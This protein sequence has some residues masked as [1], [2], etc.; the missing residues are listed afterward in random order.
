[1][2]R[3]TFPL[4]DDYPRLRR[5]LLQWAEQHAYACALDNC[6]TDVDTYGEYELLLG[7]ADSDAEVCVN[8]EDL[9]RA[10]ASGGQPWFGGLNYALRRQFE[11]VTHDR[12]TPFIQ[13]EPVCLFAAQTVVAIDR[14]CTQVTITSEAPEATWQ[15]IQQQVIGEPKPI[16]RVELQSSF[17]REEYIDTVKAIRRR[18]KMGQ[19]YEINLSQ[20][21]TAE[22]ELP[23]RV[24]L[25]EALTRIS[26]VPFATYLKWGERY[27]IGASPERFMHK[28]GRKLLSQPIKGTAA[29]EPHAPEQDQQNRDALLASEKERAENVMIVDLVR[30]D[31][32]RSC[33][34]D[35]VQV[36]HLFQLQTFQKV[37]HM[38]STIVGELNPDTD[39]LTALRRCFPAGSMTGAPKVE[40]MQHID[41]YER[42]TR[43][44]Y[45]GSLGYIAPNGDYDFNV[46]IRSFA[47]D[48]R[49]HQ[50]S[51]NMG[52]AITWDS[53]PVAEYDE[54]LIKA[55]AIR[56]LFGAV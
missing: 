2:Q 41:L 7:I 43:E 42:S 29:R 25:F 34:P 23:D 10:Y 22:V 47:Y 3:H 18:I 15:A 30:N 39:G 55:R 49:T 37:H 36:P 50:L 53:D 24:A 52:G 19:F 51:Y 44:L 45:A 16:P 21:F 9:Q 20:A 17:T 38:V 33:S 28:R 13:F 40:V 35:S 12:N 26:P 46:V 11:P 1:M 4:T 56:Q 14:A 54:T 48:A 5:R 8:W 6:Q 31:F 32:H 27:L